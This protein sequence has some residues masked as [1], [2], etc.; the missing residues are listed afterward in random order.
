MSLDSYDNTKPEQQSGYFYKTPNGE[1]REII[2]GKK[3]GRPITKR[4]TAWFSQDDK[5]DACTLYTV[6]GDL[7]E[8]SK[9]TKIPVATIRS[10]KQEPWWI[11]ITKQVY[12]ESNENLTARVASTLDKTLELLG[13][14][15][16][17]GDYIWN[18]KSEQLVR[19]PVDTKVLAILFDNLAIQRRLGRG[20]ATSIKGTTTSTDDRLQKLSEAF[21]RF[22]KMKVIEGEEVDNAITTGV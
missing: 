14:R 3:R 12:I 16:E 19:K 10:W 22:S 21:E 20:E 5:V 11:E 4:N 8:V 17:H 18:N 13:D 9:L 1:N 7:N 15:L 2:L 6:Y